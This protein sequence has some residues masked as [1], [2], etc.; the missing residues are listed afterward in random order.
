MNS[1]RKIIF[2]N[3]EVIF[4]VTLVGRV[5]VCCWWQWCC[6]YDGDPCYAS[7]FQAY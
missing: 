7:S 1:L 5:F 6:S 4:F 3:T 2:K